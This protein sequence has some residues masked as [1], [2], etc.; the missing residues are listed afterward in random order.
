M[1]KDPST[2]PTRGAAP[3]VTPSQTIRGGAADFFA[4]QRVAFKAALDSSA[5]AA[6]LM[7]QAFENLESNIKRRA[8]T[9]PPIA[10]CKGCSTCC[11]GFR[12]DA[13]GPEIFALVRHIR[14]LL[15]NQQE[16]ITDRVAAADDRTRGLTGTERARG[17]DP[18]PLLGADDACRVYPARP[19]ACRG[20]AS[21]DRQACLDAAA[22]RRT[23]VPISMPHAQMR[24]LVQTSLKAALV[25]AGLEP[26]Q[27]ELNHALRLA[28]ADRHSEEKWFCGSDVLSGA[29]SPESQDPV[30]GVRAMITKLETGPKAK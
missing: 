16:D 3:M 23:E 5:D 26:A 8:E 17:A 13:T 10:C 9:K 20:H 6:A 29:L 19:M 4:A 18:C 15:P 30:Y 21:Y 1:G 14:S 11:R 24:H 2:L 25:D 28:L 22:G 7:A 27:Y 12:V